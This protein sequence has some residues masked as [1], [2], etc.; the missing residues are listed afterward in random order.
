MKR[1]L[2]LQQGTKV[3]AVR[4]FGPVKEGAPGIITGAMEVPFFFWSRQTYLCTFANNM[5]IAARPNEIDDFDHGYSLEELEQ[6]RL[7]LKPRS[8]VAVPPPGISR[9]TCRE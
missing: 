6:P 3:I 9:M 4:N 2:P 5:R 1:P 7:M 8:Q